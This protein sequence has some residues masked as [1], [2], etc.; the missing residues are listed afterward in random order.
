MSELKLAIITDVHLGPDQGMKLGTQAERILE[1][2]RKLCD[3]ERPDLVVDLGDRIA[4]TSQAEDLLRIRQ[5]AALYRTITHPIAYV[6]GN[7]DEINGLTAADWEN[8]FSAPFSSHVRDDIHPDFRIVMFSPTYY[9]G[10]KELVAGSPVSLLASELSFLESALVTNRTCVVCTHAP[11]HRALWERAP[12][13]GKVYDNDHTYVSDWKPAKQIQQLLRQSNTC[14]VLS[15]HHHWDALAV[16]DDIA[17]IQ[18]NSATDSSTTKPHASG[19]MGLLTI[20]PDTI[21]W[22]GHGHRAPQY[23]LPRRRG[24]AAWAMNWREDD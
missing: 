7:H 13:W 6:M 4:N 14:V 19:R 9:H 8:A 12:Y 18:I 23:I 15:G 16:Q 10:N 24:N 20:G 5:V 3:E 21:R 1:S 22:Q 17:L 2:F 11:L